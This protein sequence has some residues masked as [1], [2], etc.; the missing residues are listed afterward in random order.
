MVSR[1]TFVAMMISVFF[2][3]PMA[4][5]A[6]AEDQDLGPAIALMQADGTEAVLDKIA[7]SVVKHQAGLL[8]TQHPNIQPEGL[9][10][11]QTYLLEEL[12]NQKPDLLRV[13]AELYSQ[14][15]T[16]DDIQ[17]LVVFYQTDLGKRSVE[18][19]LQ[20]QE[21]IYVL[22]AQWSTTALEKAGPRVHER[23]REEG[24]AL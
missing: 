13:I 19:M 22:G 16:A 15:L 9:E 17:Q 5:T 18:A 2:M 6:W 24:I 1:P 20:M 12:M 14:H 4:S 11:F 10:R 23:L 3:Q 21:K 8:R 7:D